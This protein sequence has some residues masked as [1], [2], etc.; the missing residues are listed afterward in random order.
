[1]F[2]IHVGTFLIF[3]A[4][5]L[6]IVVSISAPT[7]SKIDFLHISL[8]NG[9]A[10]N[11]GTLGYCITMPGGPSS[12]TPTGVGYRIANEITALG[13]NSFNGAQAASLH[14]LTEAFILHQIGAGVAAIAFLLAAC[15]HR[16]GYLVASAVALVAF[17]ISLVAMIIDFIVFASVRHHVNDN[18]GHA[19]FGNAIWMVLAATI[20][21][22]FASI[23]TCFACITGRRHSRSRKHANAY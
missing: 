11:F 19:T 4:M 13:I 1:M 2:P 10:V 12:C 14:G 16:L 23:A 15:S 20:V 18:G 3:A 9:S 17:L 6:L 7:V 5:V 8:T 21:L 22:F